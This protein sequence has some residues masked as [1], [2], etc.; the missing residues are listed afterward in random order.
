MLTIEG[1]PIP[2]TAIPPPTAPTP[3]RPLSSLLIGEVEDPDPDVGEAWRPLPVSV[4][5]LGAAEEIEMVLWKLTLGCMAGSTVSAIHVGR[6]NARLEKAGMV[7]KHQK[8]KEWAAIE[9]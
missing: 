4:R 5:F 7:R 1:S 9:Q 2:T 3:T 6:R 8:A